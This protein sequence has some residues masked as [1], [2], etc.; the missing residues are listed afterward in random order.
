[1]RY[2]YSV[3]QSFK[4]SDTEKIFNRIYCKKYS[5]GIQKIA[6]RKLLLINGSTDVND[7]RIPPGNRLEILKEDRKGQYS[8]RINDK[9]RICFKWNNGNALEVHIVDYH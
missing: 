4:D 2:I 8:I 1:M 9:Y 3:I 7:L 6:L 5:A